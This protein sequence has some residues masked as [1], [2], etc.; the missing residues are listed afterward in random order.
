MASNP[1]IRIRGLV[2]VLPYLYLGNANAASNEEA[3]Q[4]QGITHIINLSSEDVDNFFE[5][6]GDEGKGEF[7]YTNLHI[8]ETH[9][10]DAAQHFDELYDIILK[11]KDDKE[12]VLVHCTDG[13]SV[14]ATVVYAY[15][16]MASSKKNKHLPLV[17]AMD[18]V[19]GKEPGAQPR[20]NFMIQ[21]I[22]LE[23]KLYGEASMRV[24]PAKK[25]GRKGHKR[26]KGRRG[27]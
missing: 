27:H 20:E 26:G 24:K 16:M 21:L 25:Q 10:G 2:R 5:D 7:T 4:G 13:K 17:K 1:P 22:A 15:M 14:S 9:D 11:I 8:K 3:L 12:K 23:T 18:F 19:M 6:E